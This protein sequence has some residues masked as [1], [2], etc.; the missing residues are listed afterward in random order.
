MM[1]KTKNLSERLTT[2]RPLTTLIITKPTNSR[3]FS[4]ARQ[5]M[6]RDLRKEVKIKREGKIYKEHQNVLVRLT[7]FWYAFSP[8]KGDFSM[9]SFFAAVRG[10]WSWAWYEIDRNSREPIVR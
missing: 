4:I 2:L 7:S 10:G 1:A 5:Q 9:T 8:S 6:A 3:C